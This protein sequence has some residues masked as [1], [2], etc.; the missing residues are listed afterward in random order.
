MVDVR[1]KTSNDV[2]VVV[3]AVIGSVLK[4]T[5]TY[6]K[7][8]GS[9]PTRTQRRINK[10]ILFVFATYGSFIV[11]DSAVTIFINDPELLRKTIYDATPV[12]TKAAI[13]AIFPT[14]AAYFLRMLGQNE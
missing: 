5:Y 7:Y 9:L 14:L 10:T 8:S 6:R 3:N 11:A 4:T 2:T 12:F 13:I 1:Y